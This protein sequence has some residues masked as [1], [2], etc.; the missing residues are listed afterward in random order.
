MAGLSVE[1]SSGNQPVIGCPINFLVV[2]DDRTTANFEHCLYKC[3]AF[4]E[5]QDVLKKTK[6]TFFGF[7]K[8]EHVKELIYNH[9]SVIGFTYVGLK[10]PSGFRIKIGSQGRQHFVRSQ[11]F[12]FPLRCLQ[13]FFIMDIKILLNNLHEEVCCSVCMCTFTDPKQLPCL[14]SFC[15]H[16]LN[17]IQQTSGVHRKI[18]CPECRGQFCVPGNGNP[19]EFPTNFRINSLLDVLAIKECKAKAVKCGNC[20]KRNEQSFYCFQCFAFWCDDCVSLHNGIRAHKEHH[21]LALQD[22]Q[23]RDFENVLKRP[24]FC[25]KKHHEKEE[26]KLFCKDCKVAICNVCA[27]TDHERHNKGTLEMATSMQKLR[28]ESAIKSLQWKVEEKRTEIEEIDQHIAEVHVQVADI[29]SKVQT[30][31]D[32]TIAIIEAKKQDIFNAVDNQAKGSLEGLALRKSE[33]ENQVKRIQSAIQETESFS[34]RSSGAEFLGFTE[35]FDTVLE[36]HGTHGNCNNELILSFSFSENEKLLNVLNTEGIGNVKTICSETKAKQS[37]TDGKGSSEASAGPERQIVCGSSSEVRVETRRFRPVLSFGQKGSSA[38]MLNYPWSVAVNAEDEIAVTELLNHRIS[39][40]NSDGIHLRSF[41]GKGSNPGEFNYPSGIAF[42]RNGS[43]IVADRDNNRVQVFSRNGKFISEF[44]GQG[45]LFDHQ[46]DSPDGLSITAEGN[47]IV[48]DKGNK[49]IKIFSPSGEYLRKFGGV[50]SLVYPYHCIQ[51]GQYF[52]VSD[53]GDNSIKMFDL[54]G[55]FRFKFGKKG[56]NDG[57]FNG[58]CY[59]SVNKEGFL[60]VCD[61]E[62]KRVQVFE[63]SGKFVTRFGNKG[64]RTGEFKYPSS[65]TNLSDGRI[66]V[67]DNLSHKIQVFDQI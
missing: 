34:K 63:P 37:S 35:P 61:S 23:D 47:V 58:P 49:C 13:P 4:L 64:N 32:Q 67:S 6:N 38:G 48:A 41:G 28:V 43:I 20:D 14:H 53:K 5:I 57:E 22:F 2:S 45:S 66:V 7:K 18:T 40:F 25:Q 21:T 52:V 1:F 54:E 12:R 36:Q 3:H 27:V 16:C 26:L 55:K 15:L 59:L 9:H 46:L 44:G 51:Q 65:T 50:S 29:K 31:V 39:V 60:M 11:Y 24:A 8:S 19:S 56:N 30:S 17:K 10:I 62:N 42:G 33:V